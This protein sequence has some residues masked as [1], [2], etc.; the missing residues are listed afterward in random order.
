MAGKKLRIFDFDDT[1]VKT[2]SRVHVHRNGKRVASLSPGE[3]AVYEKR[4]GDTFDYSDFSD[5]KDPE[6][7]VWVTDIL[8]KFISHPDNHVYILTARG[9]YKPIKKYLDEIG[10]ARRIYVVALNS[11]DPKS[12]ADW[13]EMKINTGHYDDVYFADDSVKNVQAVKNML[14]NKQNIRWKVHHI[15]H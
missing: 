5:V 10:L 3:Y 1:L 2:N 13:I 7:I 4:P 11:A 12:K 8:R 9:V 14:K 6:E 15:V